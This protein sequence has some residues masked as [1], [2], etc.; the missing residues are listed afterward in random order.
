MSIL[1][2]HGES[3]SN[4]GGKTFLNEET[5]LTERGRQQA[6]ELFGG[7]PPNSLVVASPY[8]RARQTAEEATQSQDLETWPVQEFSFL[9]HSRCGLSSAEDRKPFVEEYWARNDPHYRDGEGA[10]SFADLLVRVD[11]ML[12]QLKLTPA[13]VFTHGNFIKAVYF[14][15]LGG[16]DMAAFRAFALSFHVPNCARIHLSFDRVW[17][18]SGP[19]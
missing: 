8:A 7:L 15:L 10:E 11:Q 2:R 17:M 9:A 6:R 1:I 3:E 18:I 12:E 19:Q 5:Q 4:A 16:T 14:R 13:L